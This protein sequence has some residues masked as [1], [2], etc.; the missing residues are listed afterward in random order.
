AKQA[1]IV[2]FQTGTVLYN[3]NGEERMPTSSMSKVLTSIVVDDALRSGQIS[4]DTKFK[5]SEK[6]WK[7]GGSRM[8]VD[9]NTEV[10][11][12]D[13]LRGVVIQSGNDACVVLAEGVSGSEANFV[14][15]MNQKAE[16]IGMSNSHFMNSNGWPDPN[17]Y[18]TAEDLT[19]LAVYLIKNYQDEYK[20]YSEKDFTYN[21]IKQGNRN[22]LLYRNIGAD[23]I[24]TGHTEDGGYG[25]MASAVAGDRRVVV[26]INGTESMQAR[27]DEGAKLT[28]WA[29][30][31]FK[32]VK[33]MEK[34]A[35]MADVPVVLSDTKTLQIVA[36]EGYFATVPSFAKGSGNVTV[37]YKSPAIAPIKE[38]DVL[39]SASFKL[40]DGSL[41][42]I[43]LI[44]KSDAPQASFFSRM[45]EKLMIMLVGVPE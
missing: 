32:N 21:N 14:V 6:A 5:V 45:A 40:P 17:H 1:Y 2:D 26:V 43:P 27:A 22:P 33:L 30:T 42:K 28:E 16:E 18:S 39:G 37:T 31:S 8:F 44:A 15:A 25:L 9:I 19:K 24:K 38:G 23:G 7:T 34:G 29:L 10:S 11:V 3:K 12:E 13:L 36:G 4:K 41:K 35:V 20:I